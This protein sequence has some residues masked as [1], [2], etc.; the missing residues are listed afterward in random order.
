LIEQAYQVGEALGLAV[1]TQDEAGPFPTMPYP[2][3]RWCPQDHPLRHPHEYERAGTAKL[4][5]L[6]HPASGTARVKGVTSC[7]NAV[8]HP[9][10]EA[11]LTT[12]LAT[13]PPA[14][15][16]ASAAANRAC[17]EH[18]R[19][20]LSERVSLSTELPPLRLLLVLDNLA[21]HKTPEFVVWCFAHGILPLYT[22]L[23]GS[24]LN[25]A[26]SFQG[27]LK[28]RALAGA[29]PQ[30][31]EEII[32]RLETVAGAW[33]RDPTPFEWGGKRAV[34]RARSRA[35]R[36]KVGGSGACTRRPMPRRQTTLEKWQ[37]VSQLPH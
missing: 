19:E 15:E 13:L 37:Q 22:P 21:G 28:G 34:R 17:W 23:G 36:H 12:I 32:R 24:W 5:T 27:V 16:P 10:L 31:P 20:G 2:G 30:T 25:M 33:N 11:E 8:L 18:W 3:A 6:F 26:E 1:W 14:A 9:W 29:Y 35:R 4:L 7:T